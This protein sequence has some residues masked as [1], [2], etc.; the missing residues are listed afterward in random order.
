MEN[1]LKNFTISVPNAGSVSIE[2]DHATLHFERTLQHPIE[3]VWD[4]LTDPEQLRGWFMTEAVLEGRVGGTV[5]MVSGPSKFHWTGKVL[6]W[7]PPHKLE[8]E[9]K[10]PIRQEMPM[11][12]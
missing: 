4:A 10:A 7:E 1:L 12:E 9:W 6:A 2:G 8:Y 11:G 3:K 5:D